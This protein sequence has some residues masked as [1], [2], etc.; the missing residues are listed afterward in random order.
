MRLAWQATGSAS[1]TWDVG[2]ASLLWVA[3]TSV[4][5]LHPGSETHTETVVPQPIG[6][7]LPRT[8]SGL[9][10]NL[11][12]G[13]G[14]RDLDDR[15][16]WLVYW[17]RDGAAAG[18]CATDPAGNLW[19]VTGDQL[20]RVEPDGRAKVVTT[21]N[22]VT[23]LAAGEEIHVATPAG[24]DLIDPR[25][26]SAHLVFEVPEGPAGLCV[27]ADGGIWVAIPAANQV[28]R[29]TPGGALDRALDVPGPTGCCFGGTDFTD[30]YIT[31]G[32]VFVA[33]GVGAGLPTA[34]FPG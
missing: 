1:P 30:L 19:A 33:S 5:R 13:I 3:G 28:R 29:Y 9:V 7:A 2:S 20:V 23:G 8:N 14:L 17:H 32:S 15:L 26:G 4:H 25:T 18:P 16:T 11:R 27:D 10:L 21:G 31:A 6:A 34:R 12:D 24:V 22:T